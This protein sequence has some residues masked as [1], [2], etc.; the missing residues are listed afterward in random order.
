[1]GPKGPQGRSGTWRVTAHCAFTTYCTL[2][3]WITHYAGIAG[4]HP[5]RGPI[6]SVAPAALVGVGG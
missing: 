6:C 1:M 3:V 4:G 2:L 5:L